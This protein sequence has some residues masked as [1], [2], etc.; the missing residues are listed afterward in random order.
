MHEASNIYQ[1]SDKK[2]IGINI[3]GLLYKGGFHTENQF[4]LS[5]DY[6]ALVEKK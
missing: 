1:F 5:I 4:G 2:K 6:P 3:S